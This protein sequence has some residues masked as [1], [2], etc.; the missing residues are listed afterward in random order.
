MGYRSA[1]DSDHS[2]DSHVAVPFALLRQI[3]DIPLFLSIGGLVVQSRVIPQGVH[4]ATAMA[5][6]AAAFCRAPRL[7]DPRLLSLPPLSRGPTTSSLLTDYTVIYAD[8][9]SSL[10]P[11][12]HPSFDNGASM[13]RADLVLGELYDAVGP[14]TGEPLYLPPITVE[15]VD[16][17]DTFLGTTVCTLGGSVPYAAYVV[18]AI[19]S[20]AQDLA[21]PNFRI[22]PFSSFGTASMRQGYVIGFFAHAE[23]MTTFMLHLASAIL[24]IFLDFVVRGWPPRVVH[25]AM[26]AR[27]LSSQMPDAFELVAPVLAPFARV[28]RTYRLPT[29]AR[30]VMLR[31][32]MAD[33]LQQ[34]VAGT[35]DVGTYA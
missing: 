8:D 3:A 1:V 21:P 10:I 7:V 17:W 35:A 4:P 2:T 22:R 33:R 19:E 16:P 14:V 9:A 26:R 15:R 34:V 23:G 29:D 31:R 6:I 28:R 24:G 12:L 11:A 25:G 18:P 27:A 13:A 30:G 32:I 5:T 20:L